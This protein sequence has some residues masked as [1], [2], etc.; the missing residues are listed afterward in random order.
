MSKKKRLILMKILNLLSIIETTKNQS[1][2]REI[3]GLL[4]SLIEET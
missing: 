3:E 2:I 4:F 1:K